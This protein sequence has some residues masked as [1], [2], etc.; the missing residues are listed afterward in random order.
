MP[1]P[2]LDFS[3]T[4]NAGII[5]GEFDFA[6][7]LQIVA[8]N[9]EF[10]PLVQE[11]TQLFCAVESGWMRDHVKIDYQD[12]GR[13][14]EVGWKFTDFVSHGNGR[15]YPFDVETGTSKM[16]AQPALGPAFAIVTPEYKAELE[17]ATN[18][19]VRQFNRRL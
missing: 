18:S 17:R 19:V 7:E 9:L 13:E 5:L 1:S 2:A 12:E 3:V 14:F 16:P 8:T 11:L 10:A 6:L 15:F 4:G